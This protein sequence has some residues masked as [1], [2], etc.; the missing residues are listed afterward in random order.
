VARVV[1]GCKFRDGGCV[2]VHLVIPCSLGPRP[3]RAPS[4]AILQQMIV[5]VK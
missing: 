4:I 5:S 3:V 1:T 2:Y